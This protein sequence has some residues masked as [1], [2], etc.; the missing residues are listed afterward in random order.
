MQQL[1]EILNSEDYNT[2]S[3]MG[4]KGSGKTFGLAVMAKHINKQVWIFDT[5][6]AISKNSL[7][8][9][10]QTAYVTAAIMPEKKIREI[11]NKIYESKIKY[12]V[13]DLS[14]FIPEELVIFAND[15]SKWVLNKGNVAVII[16]EIVDFC[17]QFG[18]PYSSGLQRLWRAG[19]NYGV[20]PVVMATQRPQ[21]SDKKIFA[22]AQL[23]LVMK[24]LHPRDRK[25]IEDIIPTRYKEQWL[26]IEEKIIQME[27]QHALVY[28]GVKNK[29]YN[30][31]FPDINEEEGDEK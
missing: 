11:L 18:T 17:P 10:K 23:Y 31:K 1:T 5:L 24:L 30:F 15:F 2:I 4:L 7:L 12:V 14:K 26:E 3:V 6:G 20:W 21:E 28:D 13:I 19:R 16:D 22:H 27:K 29:L 9:T 8:P 25:Q